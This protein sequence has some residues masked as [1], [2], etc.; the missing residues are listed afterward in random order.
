MP[1]LLQR[2]ATRSLPPLEGDLRAQTDKS[3][4]SIKNCIFFWA[5]ALFTDWEQGLGD[6]YTQYPPQQSMKML[7]KLTDNIKYEECEVRDSC[8]VCMVIF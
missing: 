1:A 4:A 8:F 3:T 5:G 6:T 2:C 7:W